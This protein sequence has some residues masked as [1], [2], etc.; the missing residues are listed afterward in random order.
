MEPFFTCTAAAPGSDC[1][2][3]AAITALYDLDGHVDVVLPAPP[4]D[5]SEEAAAELLLQTE[6]LFGQLPLVLYQMVQV[7]GLGLFLHTQRTQRKC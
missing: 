7:R 2:R 4:V 1:V 3:V 6:L 5:V